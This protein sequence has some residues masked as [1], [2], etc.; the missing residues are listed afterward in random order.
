MEADAMNF[1]IEHLLAT[2]LL[3]AIKG[4]LAFNHLT[5]HLIGQNFKNSPQ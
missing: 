2:L 4:C 3:I 1:S 5:N